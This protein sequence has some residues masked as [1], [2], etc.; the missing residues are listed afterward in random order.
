[1]V[2][3]CERVR[4]MPRARRVDPMLGGAALRAWRMDPDGVDRDTRAL[5]VRFTLEELGMRAPG[6]SVEVRVPPWGAVQCL[7][8][9]VHRRGTPA[10]VVECDDRTWLGLACGVLTWASASESGALRISGVRADL[11]EVL[12]LMV[13]D[14]PGAATAYPGSCD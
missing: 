7:A 3:I 6:R 13:D 2:T 11:S 5:A 8:G 12:P 14:G 9:P 10:N 1:M 4:A